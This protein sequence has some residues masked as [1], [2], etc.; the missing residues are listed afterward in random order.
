M[1][2]K[3]TIQINIHYLRKQLLCSCKCRLSVGIDIEMRF[4]WF[5]YQ[6]LDKVGSFTCK[7]SI[8]FVCVNFVIKT[9]I[10]DDRNFMLCY[11][12]CS[13]IGFLCSWY[14]ICLKCSGTCA[15]LFDVC[16]FKFLIVTQPNLAMPQYWLDIQ[17][18]HVNTTTFGP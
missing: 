3:G 2:R 7:L 11:I 15:S 9:L 10:S 13:V 14:I 4:N 12:S 8:I 18:N 16:I 6:F 5:V 17:Q 1:N